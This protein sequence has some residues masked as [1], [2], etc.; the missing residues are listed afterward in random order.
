MRRFQRPPAC[1]FSLQTPHRSKP[2]AHPHFRSHDSLVRR[3]EQAAR[4]RTAP[5]RRQSS[6][7][8]LWRHMAHR[9]CRDRA[10]RQRTV[11]SNAFESSNQCQ[12]ERR[13][14]PASL[15]L[16]SRCE[17]RLPRRGLLAWRGRDH[18]DLL[19]LRF[20]RFSITSLL[21]LRHF[22]LLRL[23]DTDGKVSVDG[24]AR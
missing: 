18:L 15:F 10:A 5:R 4:M 22:G 16:L 24:A 7:N 8:F 9:S 2:V 14:Q 13:C 12:S 19:F 11:R 1:L 23:I 17:A 6:S 3:R 20:L 21:A